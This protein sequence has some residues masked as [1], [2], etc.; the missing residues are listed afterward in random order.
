MRTATVT[1]LSLL[2][3]ISLAGCNSQSQSSMTPSEEKALRAAPG[4]PMPPEARAM[5]QKA[6][7]APSGPITGK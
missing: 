3:L 1:A 4:Q 7:Q 5:M 6:N 2:G